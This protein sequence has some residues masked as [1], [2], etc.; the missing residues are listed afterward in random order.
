MWFSPV[1]GADDHEIAVQAYND[2]V[3][4]G[5]M[6]TLAHGRWLGDEVRM[7]VVGSIV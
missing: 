7:Y 6:R 5:S 4:K 1:Y 2:I 3:S